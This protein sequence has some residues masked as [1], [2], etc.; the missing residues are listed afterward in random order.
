[1]ETFPG[2]IDLP[3]KDAPRRLGVHQCEA[4]A[5]GPQ[6]EDTVGAILHVLQH[7]LTA[8][9]NADGLN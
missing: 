5:P 9:T 8:M 1:M 3:T 2:G 7:I 6:W 4:A